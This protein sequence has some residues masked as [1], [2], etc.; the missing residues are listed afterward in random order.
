MSQ[1]LATLLTECP[2]VQVQLED[3]FSQVQVREPLPFLQAVSMNS[4]Q[5]KQEVSP[6]S[7]RLKTIVVRFDQDIPESE[8]L[9][10]Q[11]NP[12]CVASSQRGDKTHDYTLDPQVNLRAEEYIDVQ[13]LARIC[14]TNATYFGGRIDKLVNAVDKRL[15]TQV[16]Q[17]AAVLTGK[18]AKDV[19][20]T[21]DR[22]VIATLKTGSTTDPNPVAL[23]KLERALMQTGFNQTNIFGGADLWDYMI[24]IKAGCC[25]T[26]GL[27]L[28]EMLA[29]Y[30]HTYSYDRRLAAALGGNDFALAIQPNALTL[31]QYTVNGWADGL[32]EA[33]HSGAY[34]KTVIQSPTSG[35]MMDLTIKDDCGAVHILVTAT[36]KLVGMP[37][38]LYPVGD[39]YEGVKYANQIRVVNA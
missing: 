39:I 11:S 38:D 22:F 25:S 27:N 9:S 29:Q 2:E 30:G 8:V 24:A 5:L 17:Q 18:W 19:T 4:S 14:R 36:T 6:S 21:L 1:I 35:V 23:A 31:L 7:N 16:A 3:A 12:A 13:D 37:D 32:P 34:Y 26:N 15:A 33:Y 20:T 28:A 10:N